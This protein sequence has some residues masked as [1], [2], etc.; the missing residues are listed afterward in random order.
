MLSFQVKQQ[1]KFADSL[2]YQAAQNKIIYLQMDAQKNLILPKLDTKNFVF[3]MKLNVHNNTLLD[4]SSGRVMCYLF[5]DCDADLTAS[6]FISTLV[7]FLKIICPTKQAGDI[8]VESDTCCAANRNRYLSNALLFLAKE[9]NRNI[10]QIFFV[11][12]HSFMAVDTVH[13][14]IERK[15]KPKEV[16][17]VEVYEKLINESRK[18]SP[19]ETKRIDHQFVL[20]YTTPLPIKSIKPETALVR[21]I[22][23]I[24]YRIDGKVEI[25]TSYVKQEWK[26][27]RGA[28]AENEEIPTRSQLRSQPIPL[29][30]KKYKDIMSMMTVIPASDKSFF[31]TLPHD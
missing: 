26:E 27:L 3:K 6:T 20:D 10:T 18:G 30:S 4:M 21:D 16:T 15:I 1:K 31:E 17:S 19:L 9:L 14:L 13:S 22:R 11:P 24:K 23:A 7:D 25:M 2:K 12:G 29:S 28:L 8:F 5:S